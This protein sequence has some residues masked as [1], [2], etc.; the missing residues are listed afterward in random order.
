MDGWMHGWM[1]GWMDGYVR[2]KRIM[3]LSIL[4]MDVSDPSTGIGGGEPLLEDAPFNSYSF[5]ANRIYPALFDPNTPISRE[6]RRVR[7][8]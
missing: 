8:R 6:A 5:Y 3:V 2:R 1:H 7:M 4:G